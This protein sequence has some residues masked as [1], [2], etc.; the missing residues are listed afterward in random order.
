MIGFL[1]TSPWADVSARQREIGRALQRQ[2][3]TVARQAVPDQMIDLLRRADE[4]WLARAGRQV[5]FAAPK[6]STTSLTVATAIVGISIMLF[7]FYDV[8]F[9]AAAEPRVIAAG[10]F[11][12]GL[13]ATF[14]GAVW[15]I[16]GK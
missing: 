8:A 11:F 10:A 13:V 2:Y 15:L 14:A 3:D 6:A 9:Y 4:R 5:E 16:E 7:A 12:T 1:S